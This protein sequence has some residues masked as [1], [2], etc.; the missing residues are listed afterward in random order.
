MRPTLT[1]T[2]DVETQNHEGVLSPDMET[3][4]YAVEQAIDCIYTHAGFLVN[5]E[6]TEGDDE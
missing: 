6:V 5:V 1:I 4:A 2:F 3:I